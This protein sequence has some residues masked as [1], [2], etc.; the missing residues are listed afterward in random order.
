MQYSTNLSNDWLQKQAKIPWVVYLRSFHNNT[1]SVDKILM[2]TENKNLCFKQ[3]TGKE[4]NLKIYYSNQIECCSGV[5]YSEAYLYI[6]FVWE[7]CLVID[8]FVFI[9]SFLTITSGQTT[10]GKIKKKKE[11][12]K[13]T[14]SVSKFLTVSLC[15]THKP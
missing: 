2:K 8:F 7:N 9:P 14:L 11:K 15:K 10:F 6:L 1:L 13:V 5:F 3:H 12:A 4:S